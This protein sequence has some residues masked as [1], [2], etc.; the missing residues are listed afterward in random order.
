MPEDSSVLV[1]DAEIV[2]TEARRRASLIVIQAHPEWTLA[3]LFRLDPQLLDS[4]CLG[5]LWGAPELAAWL[6][7]MP[8]TRLERALLADGQHFDALV[9]EVICEVGEPVKPRNLRARL[10][11]PRWKL[12]GSLERLCAQGLV[13]REGSTSDTRY[14]AVLNTG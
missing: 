12:K 9:L 5:E 3:Q 8:L 13:V 2:A 14:E 6:E 10:G 11:G 1:I 4:L 7:S